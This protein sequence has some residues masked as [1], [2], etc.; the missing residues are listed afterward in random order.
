MTYLIADAFVEHANDVSLLV[1][2]V[3]LGLSYKRY[4]KEVARLGNEELLEN[5]LKD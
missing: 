3:T 2:L 1:A 5:F 4:K